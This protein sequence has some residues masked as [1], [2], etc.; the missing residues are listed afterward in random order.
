MKIDGTHGTDTLLQRMQ[1]AHQSPESVATEATND[2]GKGFRVADVS[3]TAP[4]EATE[5]TEATRLVSNLRSTAEKALRGEFAGPS[6]VRAEVV[7]HIL[8]ERW[9]AKLG[10]AKTAKM[11]RTMKPT[12]VDDPE[13][14][15]EVDEMLI[16]AAR[17]LGA[18]RDL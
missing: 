3:P 15:R 4:T 16:M 1:E 11:I 14:A 5:A 12:L 9:E 13:F 2:V 7:D 6:E 18:A 17:E 10:K 8:R